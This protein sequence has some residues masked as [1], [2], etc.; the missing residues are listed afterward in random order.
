MFCIMDYFLDLLLF[1]CDN[2]LPATDL[3]ESL[4]LPSFKIF[5]AIDA[6]SLLVVLFGVFF[7]AIELVLDLKLSTL[8]LKIKLIEFGN[9]LVIQ[10]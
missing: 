8:R 7:F 6:T 1:L 2:A 3:L 9:N 10:A 4:N 5:E